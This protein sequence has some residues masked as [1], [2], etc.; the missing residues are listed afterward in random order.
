M[1]SPRLRPIAS[2]KRTS[3]SLGSCLGRSS[4]RSTS[5]GTCLMES[6]NLRHISSLF[7]CFDESESFVR[8]VGEAV[9]ENRI[10]PAAEAQ[11]FIE[12]KRTGVRGAN[13]KAKRHGVER[14]RLVQELEEAPA[15]TSVARL[16]NDE[17]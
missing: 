14:S 17:H 5:A 7:C 12:P 8:M 10:L 4:I 15:D 16:W 1:T 6:D 11:R 13:L 3:F 2:A 9:C